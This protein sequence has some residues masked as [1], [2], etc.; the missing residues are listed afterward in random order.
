ML[1]GVFFFEHQGYVL[2][3]DDFQEDYSTKTVVLKNRHA[4]LLQWFNWLILY[5]AAP[6][7]YKV[8]S[9]YPD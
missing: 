3:E 5:F 7:L 9:S 4:R 2:T 1:L 8:T 6:A